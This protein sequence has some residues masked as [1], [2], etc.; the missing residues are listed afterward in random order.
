MLQLDL[1]DLALAAEL[2]LDAAARRRSCSAREQSPQPSQTRLVDEEAPRRIDQLALLAAAAL[3]G[4]AGLL[5]D[6]HRHAGH[7]AQ[8][9]LHR[10]ELGAVVEL[11][12]GRE[13]AP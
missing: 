4:G 11:G 12:A 2:G 13:L 8:A 10:V 9:A 5:V 3:L 6:Q 7:L 1:V